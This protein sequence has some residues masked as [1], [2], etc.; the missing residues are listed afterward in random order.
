MTAIEAEGLSSL[1]HLTNKN[2]TSERKL[3][4]ERQAY[5]K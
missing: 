1:H 2:E 3:N 4:N 5:I